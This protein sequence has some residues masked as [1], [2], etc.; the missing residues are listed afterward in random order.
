M[1]DL[2]HSDAF[3]A[4]PGLEAESFD[5]VITDPPYSSGGKAMS[6]KQGKVGAEKYFDHADKDFDDGTRDQL[7]HRLW[8]TDW[9]RLCHRLIKP[10]GWC[11]VFSDWRQLPLTCMAMQCAGFI[12]QGVNIWH[13]PNGL[14]QLGRFF[15]AD[16]F[17]VIGSKGEPP[18]GMKLRGTGAVTYSQMWQGMLS[19]KERYHATSKPVALMRHLMQVL[20]PGSHVLDPFA[21]GG[22]TL[23]AAAELGHHATGIE[24]TADNYETARRRV[25]ELLHT[26]TD[27]PA[28]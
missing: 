9:L 26:L 3:S 27:T 7:A 2:I 20:P 16:E 10:G 12:W 4:L 13:K 11:M 23:V 18:G 14:P 1:I 24:V 19:P 6:R 28:P 15:R 17:I 25:A 22:A 21:G 8:T 5:A